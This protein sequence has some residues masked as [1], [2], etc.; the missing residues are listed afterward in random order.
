MSRLALTFLTALAF[1]T[2]AICADLGPY[3]RHETYYDE[4]A[5]PPV[6]R[7]RIIERHYYP[8]P[9]YAEPRVVYPEPRVYYAPRVYAD[10][11]YPRPYAYAYAYAGWRP[12]YF[13]PRAPYWHH[14]RHGW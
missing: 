14:R 7:E 4:P 6:V 2:P 9:Y 11:Y 8:A 12:R 10:T 1:S 3:P 13:Y 5:P